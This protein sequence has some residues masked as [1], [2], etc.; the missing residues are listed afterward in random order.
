MSANAF[1]PLFSRTV[2]RRSLY[3]FSGVA[4]AAAAATTVAATASAADNRK[5][6]SYNNNNNNNNGN[7]RSGW[8]FFGGAAAAAAPVVHFA[9]VNKDRSFDDYQRIYNTIAEKIREEDE[10]DGYIGY[11][12]ILVRLGW[13]SSGTYDK[14]DNTGGSYGGTMR[15]KLEQ[16]DGANNGLGNARAFMEPILKEFPWIS[17]GDLYTLGAVCAVQELQ[18]PKVKWRP[19]RVDMPEDTT[20]KNGRLPDAANGAEYVRNFYARLNMNDREAVA[21]TGAHCLGRTHLKN[22]GFDGPWGAAS[23]SFTNEFFVNLLNEQWKLQK[24]KAGNMQ[25]DSPKGYMMLETDYALVQ[26]P[27]YLK[28]VKEFANN[29]GAFFKEFASCFQKLLENGIDYPK[30]APTYVFKTLDEQDL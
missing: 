15:F 24:N 8:G 6:Y 5:Y 9:A 7:R 19:G 12:P 13:H 1:I 17:H 28:I 26:D 23:N 2:S 14:N 4:A 10:Y 11:G 25:Y 3:L 21:L 30:D 18:G 27:A 16:S 29:E 20:P 22:S